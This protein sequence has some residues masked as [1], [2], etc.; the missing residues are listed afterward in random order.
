[1]NTL[2]V[3]RLDL[4]VICETWLTSEVP[5]S[6]VVISEYNF[7]RKDVAGATRKHGV[8]LYIRKKIQAIMIDLSVANTLVVHVLEWD[9]YTF[10]IA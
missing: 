7:F 10:I 3:Q 2:D 5:Y 1:M 4:L 8:G 6:F 9:T